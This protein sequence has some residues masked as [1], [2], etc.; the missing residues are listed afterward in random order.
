MHQFADGKHQALCSAHLPNWPGWL[1]VLTNSAA[2]LLVP[3]ASG[4]GSLWRCKQ[5]LL[6]TA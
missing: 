5:Y 1:L 6:R 2:L 3:A 4:S